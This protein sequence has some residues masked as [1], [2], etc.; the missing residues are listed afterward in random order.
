VG[1]I[2]YNLIDCD[3]FGK[4]ETDSI[5]DFKG[6]FDFEEALTRPFLPSKVAASKGGAQ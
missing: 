5:D 1:N 2:V 6:G 3:Y 4:M